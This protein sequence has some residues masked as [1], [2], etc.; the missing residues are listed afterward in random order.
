MFLTEIQSGFCSTE[1]DAS[2][3]KYA[4]NSLMH[5]A[6]C[7]VNTC[8]VI[9]GNRKRCNFAKPVWQF[10]DAQLMSLQGIKG[11]RKK[12]ASLQ[13]PVDNSLMHS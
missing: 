3:K 4:G 6:H 12:D 10:F 7:T 1:K 8:Q 13:N 9:K 5:T 11:N 2:L